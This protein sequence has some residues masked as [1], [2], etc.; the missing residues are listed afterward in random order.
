MKLTELN[1]AVT[2]TEAK[3]RATSKS[4]NVYTIDVQRNKDGKVFVT[5]TDGQGNNSSLSNIASNMGGD[6]GS[7]AVSGAI[8]KAIADKKSIPAALKSISGFDWSKA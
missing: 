1:E 4:G 5:M 3:F 7:K 2:L 8:E 6:A